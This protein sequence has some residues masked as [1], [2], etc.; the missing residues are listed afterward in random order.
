MIGMF[1]SGRKNRRKRPLGERVR[2]WFDK[3][4]S[5]GRRA[6]PV[7]F[8]VAVAVGLPYGIFHAYIHTVSGHYFQ[9]ETIDVNGLSRVDRD[10]LLERAGLLDGVNIF[11]V[12]AEKAAEAIEAHPWIREARME[13]RLPDQV[14]VEVTE[15]EPAAV[16]VDDGYHL[17]DANGQVFKQ[18]SAE[19]ADS[20]LLEL[21]LVTG[22]DVTSSS[23]EQ[24]RKRLVEALEV[25][26]MYRA[27]GLADWQPLS[28]VH[29]DTVL[30]LS[31]VTADSGTE[32]RLG[33]GR[34]RER[35][36]RLEVVQSSLVE[37]GIDA[38]YIL[39]DQESDLS[40]IAV[41]RR[42]EPMDGEADGTGVD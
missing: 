3:L 37:R 35:L 12:D 15:Y 40:R 25:V 18:M 22:L 33:Q 39:I 41:G 29:F 16:L 38:E 4:V 11:D 17:V 7:V 23:P 30:G 10:A 24:L 27:R 34:Y 21:P 42:V 1:G 26:E 36:E 31:V 20:G 6:I 28:E 9:L 14:V 19:E 13:R 5:L 2:G 32:I 8:L